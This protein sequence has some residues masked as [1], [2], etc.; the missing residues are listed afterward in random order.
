MRTDLMVNSFTVALCNTKYVYDRGHQVNLFQIFEPHFKRNFVGVQD[1]ARAFVHMLW[2]ATTGGDGGVYNL[3]LPT[4]NLTK[5]ELAHKV[6]DTIGLSR[7]LVTVGEGTDP[8][9]RNYLVSNDKILKTGF[10]FT[11]TLEDGIREVERVAKMC[12]PD[13]LNA[14]RNC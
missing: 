1:V 10:K 6:C 13:S 3:G 8:D 2:R 12:P 11:H 4:A 9:R 5:L 7:E 14:M